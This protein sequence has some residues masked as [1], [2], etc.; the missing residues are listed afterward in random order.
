MF[1][2]NTGIERIDQEHSW[3]E[4]SLRSILFSIG[5]GIDRHIAINT[6]SI[7]L[8]RMTVHCRDEESI[9]IEQGFHVDDIMALKREHAR[10]L[11]DFAAVD[12]VS[13]ESADHDDVKNIVAWILSITVE[14]I[15]E[16]DVPIFRKHWTGRPM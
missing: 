13:K 15:A 9:A 12:A 5:S 3:I 10:L 14:H 11:S 4:Q 6:L 2:A 7:I 8:F 1:I 16:V